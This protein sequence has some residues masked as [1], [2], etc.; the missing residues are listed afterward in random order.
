MKDCLWYLDEKA[1]HEIYNNTMKISDNTYNG[2]INPGSLQSVLEH[3]QN[4]LYYPEFEDKLTHLFLSIAKFH[5]FQDGNKRSAIALST[6]FLIF[7]GYSGIVAEFVIEME[8]F[9]VLVASNA[10]SVDLC[11]KIIVSMLNGDYGSDE[12][13]KLEILKA[14]KQHEKIMKSYE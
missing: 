5:C 10:M 1:V 9:V 6:A 11:K 13:L 2:V 7:N 3:I 14:Y 8:R 12:S 4:D